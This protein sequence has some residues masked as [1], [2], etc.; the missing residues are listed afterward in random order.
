MIFYF[1][2]CFLFSLMLAAL[3]IGNHKIYGTFRETWFT[4]PSEEIIKNNEVVKVYTSNIKTLLS[5][6]PNYE[7]Y[8]I[9]L[10]LGN[11]FTVMRMSMGDFAIIA[12]VEYIDDNLQTSKYEV[13]VFWLVLILIVVVNCVIFMNFMVAEASNTYNTVSENLECVIQ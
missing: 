3:G 13:Q 12:S 8:K 10:L 1:I 6:A 7:Y 2:E 4:F 9:G 11:F 5:D